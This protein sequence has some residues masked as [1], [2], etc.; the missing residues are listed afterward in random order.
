MKNVKINCILCGSANRI[1]LYSRNEWKVYKC[2]KCNLGVLDPQPDNEELANLYQQEY[3]QSHYNSELLP[4]SPEMKKRISQEKHR[5]R[6]FK[7][8]K[9]KGNVLDIGCG[10]GYF[11]LACLEQGY[12]VE[13]IDINFFSKLEDRDI[14]FIDSSHVVRIGGD[15]NFLY[16]E[17]LPRLKKGVIIHIHDIFFPK[18]YPKE[19]VIRNRNFWSEQYLLQSFLTFNNQFEVLW[20]GSYINL[21]QPERLRS[22]F[23]SPGNLGF[24]ENYF[25]SSF[26]MRKTA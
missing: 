25:S 8:F 11:L 19:W 5:L 4:G 12:K 24:R 22:T 17:V 2:I 6:F 15:V 1:V 23:P 7:K 14:L 10:R 13:G 20:C 26:W 21:K 18:N 9:K 3:F 16:L